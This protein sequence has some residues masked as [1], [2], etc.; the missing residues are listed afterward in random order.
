MILGILEEHKGPVQYIPRHEVLRPDSNSTPVRI[1]F[2]SSASFMRHVLNDYWAKGSN[3]MNALI[4]VRI[5]FM[6][7]YVLHRSFVFFQYE[8]SPRLYK[9]CEVKVSIYFSFEVS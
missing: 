8:V 1:V 7:W 4:A 2:N 5:R 9:E 6:V 3:I